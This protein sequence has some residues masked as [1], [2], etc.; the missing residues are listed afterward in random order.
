[1]PHKRS[2]LGR[3][4]KRIKYEVWWKFRRCRICPNCGYRGFRM[5]EWNTSYEIS[6][7]FI[8]F[9]VNCPK[10]GYEM[11]RKEEKLPESVKEY[12][13]KKNGQFLK[14]IISGI[15][16]LVYLLERCLCLLAPFLLL[17]GL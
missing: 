12:L 6:T 5:G 9:R 10:C 7:E 11:S 14:K 8:I 2:P 1:M 3:L 13:R 15:L 4:K 17:D 16:F